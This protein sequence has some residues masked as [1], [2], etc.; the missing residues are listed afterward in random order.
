MKPTLLL[1]FLFLLLSG[2][3]HLSSTPCEN[4]ETGGK[5]CS[6]CPEHSIGICCGG[7]CCEGNCTDNVCTEIKARTDDDD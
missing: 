2:C 4:N 6:A 3:S 5:F 1:P 7:E